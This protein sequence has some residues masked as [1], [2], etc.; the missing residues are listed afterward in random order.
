MTFKLGGFYV[1]YQLR[2]T[3]FHRIFQHNWSRGLSRE[4]SK[5]FCQFLVGQ[6]LSFLVNSLK[7]LTFENTC[8]CRALQFSI[9]SCSGL[10]FYKL[11]LT[12]TRPDPLKPGSRSLIINKSYYF[13]FCF[14][15][16]LYE[17]FL[18]SQILHYT[19]KEDNCVYMCVCV[20][21]I[22]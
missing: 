4:V 1:W 13:I 9:L 12:W 15:P 7:L 20:H 3:T 6:D 21:I 19:I 17:F 11:S 2:S 16:G 10:K 14:C 5:Y 18:I 22:V 8:Q